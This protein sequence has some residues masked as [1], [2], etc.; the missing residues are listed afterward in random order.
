M[1][2]VNLIVRL[3]AMGQREGVTSREPYVVRAATP[4]LRIKAPSSA[5]ATASAR[6]RRAVSYD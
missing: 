3:D 2:L 6:Y 4:S 1:D 5:A